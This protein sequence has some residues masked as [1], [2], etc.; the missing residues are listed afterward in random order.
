[1]LSWHGWP[2]ASSAVATP[3]QGDLSMWS[4]WDRKGPGA[5]CAWNAGWGLLGGNGHRWSWGPIDSTMEV[6]RMPH[7]ASE[8]QS[9]GDQDHDC[10]QKGKFYA[11]QSSE[12]DEV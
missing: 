10:A 4:P 2:T 8:Q 3:E 5:L 12:D 11:P 7:G 1:M 9:D 6:L